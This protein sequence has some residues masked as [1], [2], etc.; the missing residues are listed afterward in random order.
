MRTD[1]KLNYGE[2]EAIR[3]RIGGFETA[4]KDLQDAMN[5]V[6][7]FLGEQES[8][9]V[10]KLKGKIKDVTIEMEEKEEV[11]GE[12][13]SIV[14]DYIESMRALVREQGGG[15]TRVDTVDIS[16]N[17]QQIGGSINELEWD[18]YSPVRSGFYIGF[19]KE[20][21]KKKKRYERN[22]RKLENFRADSLGR[23]VSKLKERMEELQDIYN[24]Y[25]KQY[26]QTDDDY[27]KSINDLYDKSTSQ[28]NKEKNSWNT[29]KDLSKV[30]LEKFIVASVAAVVAGFALAVLPGMVILGAAVIVAAGCVV[31]ANTPEEKVPNWLKGAKQTSDAVADKA[32]QVVNE[33]PG[34]LVEDIGQ[35]F[36]DT[37]QTP[38]GIAAVS[39][40]AL[41]SLAGGYVG[42]KVKPIKGASGAGNP[43]DDVANVSDDVVT[44]R[45]VQGGSGTAKSQQRI[46]ID[47]NGKILISNKDKNLNISIDGGEHSQY[48]LSKRPGA[49]V[50]EFDVPKWLD[51]FVKESEVSQVGYKSNP[52]NQGGSAPKVTDI[53]TPGKSVEFPAPWAEWIEEYAT[54][55][56][57]VKGGS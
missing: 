40:E 26:E 20:A 46:S 22:Y 42:T 56:R 1:L 49:E 8:E 4:I 23:L 13:K 24:N 47:E 33:G 16:W 12:L 11:L 35:G 51:D 17:L 36:M 18:V 6:K 21:E 7:R 19:G 43:I 45:R 53:A 9:A 34:V 30:F 44:Y 27:R 25:I 14:G 50:V 55:V 32:V 54:N 48:F 28:A 39:G 15:Q 31:L 57:I 5:S 2:L 37:I 3:D 52:L 29:F 38:Q 10:K 41:G